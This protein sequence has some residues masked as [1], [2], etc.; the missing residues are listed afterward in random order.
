ML[1]IHPAIQAAGIVL[2][3]ISFITGFQR[4]R[5]LHLGQRVRFPWKWH[6]IAGKTTMVL[7]L[8][9]LPLGLAMVRITWGSNLMTMGHG[10]TALVILPLLIFGFV[11]GQV[12]DAKKGRRR[13]L[14]AMHG[15]NNALLLLM[16]LNQA[17]TGLEVY[18]T[19]VSGL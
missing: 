15:I 13:L 3:L 12:L 11:S 2:A 7:L 19:F 17:R 4:F 1:L 10:K 8:I 18:R 9:G 16:I 14:P 5:S 6:V